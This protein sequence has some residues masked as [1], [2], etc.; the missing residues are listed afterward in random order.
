[1]GNTPLTGYL[2]AKHIGEPKA[3]EIAFVSGAAGAT[4]LV[5]C[6]TFKNHGC[7][8]LG[9]AGADDKV[10]LLASLGVEAF[11]YKKETIL[12]GLRRLAPGGVN[13][14]FDNVGGETL[15][16]ALEMMNDRGR[17]LLCGAISQYDKP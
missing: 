17:V 6:Q 3:G 7:R 15:E 8:V 16:A 4:G 10:A 1:M 12:H 2:A 9:S 5:A 14:C 13:I 11:N